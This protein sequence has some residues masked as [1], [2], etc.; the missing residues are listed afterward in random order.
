MLV[1][2]ILYKEEITRKIREKW[3]TKDAYN[4][5]GGNFSNNDVLIR[6]VVLGSEGHF[7]YAVLDG[8]K[9]VGYFT[10]CID[11]KN[12]QANSFGLF[13]LTDK[14]SIVLMRDVNKEMKRLMENRWVH[15]I[16]WWAFS[17]NPACRG[18]RKFCE[19]NGGEVI[20]IKDDHIGVDC[21]YHDSLIFQIIIRRDYNDIGV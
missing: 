3:H 9:L 1:P 18:Y 15:R 10:Y 11:Y 16:S 5:T 17:E 2:A 20:V 21:Y 8:E 13:N 4:F 6:F 7:Q 19:D 12:K 14:P